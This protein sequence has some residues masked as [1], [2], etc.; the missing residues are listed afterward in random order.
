MNRAVSFIFPPLILA[1]FL[2]AAGCLVAMDG[3]RVAARAALPEL[4]A[5]LSSTQ[6]TTLA[7]GFAPFLADLHWI[8]A[9][10]MAGGDGRAEELFF[11]LDRVTTLDP[12]FEPAYHY[13]ALLLSVAGRRVDLS[14]RLLERARDRFPDSWSYS[15]YLGFNRFYYEGD[16]NAAAA[17]FERAAGQE[18]SPAYLGSLAQRFRDQAHNKDTAREL[19]TRLIAATNDRAMKARLSERLQRL[20]EEGR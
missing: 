10:G 19:L 15:F 13:G 18:G 7:G 5:L 12:D 8:R 17:H 14:D 4:P 16:F 9:M 3:R 20:E 1:A 2:V 11:L 6:L